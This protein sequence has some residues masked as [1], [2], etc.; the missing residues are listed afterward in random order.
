MSNLKNAVAMFTFSSKLWF[1]TSSKAISKKDGYVSLYLQVY[2]G[3]KGHSEIDEFRIN[4]RWPPDKIDKDA[5]ELKP[6]FP[7]DPDVNDFNL[8]IMGERSKHSEIAKIYRL[9]DK[10]LDLESFKRELKLFDY[11]KSLV[12]YMDRRRKE[13]VKKKEIAEQTYKNIGTTIKAIK[14]YQEFVRFDELDSKWMDGFKSWL[15]N[16]NYAAGTV[17]SRIKD[18]KHYL[19]LANDEKTIHVD[20]TAYEYPN[21]EPQNITIF[22]NRDEIKR[23]MMLN[24]PSYLT[25]TEHVVLRAFLFTCFTSLRISDVYVAGNGM[26]ITKNMLTFT[27]QKNRSKKPKRIHIPLIPIAK[28]LIDESLKSFFDLPSTQEY[29]RTLKDLAFK[30][31]INKKLTSHVGRHTFGY[32]YMT[33]VGNLYGLKEILGHTKIET[34]ERYAHIDDEYQMEQA[35]LMQ[36]GFEGVSKGRLRSYET[37]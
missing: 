36:K 8:I 11:R 13:L 34:T 2:I 37:V 9:S 22:C 35:M 23:L 12:T 18:I 24:D 33:S 19:R 29:N 15:I 17:W 5:S 20:P 6:R 3:K 7:K 31:G 25:K 32:L 21:P 16:K 28:T 14:R 26:M 4:L 10:K 27:A 30:A 1:N